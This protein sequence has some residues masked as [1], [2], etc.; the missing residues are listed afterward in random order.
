MDEN[1]TVV[2]E[3]FP[4]ARI[5]LHGQITAQMKRLGYNTC[6]YSK[7]GLGIELPADWPVAEN[8]QPTLAELIVVAH[9]LNMRIIIHNLTLVPREETK[10]VPGK[11]SG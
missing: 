2:I 9:K 7:L 10:D 11:L 8:A 6:D 3:M 1:E 5:G 4:D